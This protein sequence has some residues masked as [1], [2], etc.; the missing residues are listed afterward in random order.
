MALTVSES[1]A[2]LRLDKLLH[3]HFGAP[4]RT[5]FESLIEKGFVLVN[6]KP[7]KKKDKPKI[8]D[9]IEV[10]F[11]LTEEIALEPEAIPLDILYE[12]DHLLAINK[13][14]GMVVHPGAGHFA[15][16]FVH[17]LLYHCKNL[18][19]GNTLRPGIVHRLDKDTSGILLAAKTY[20]AHQKL[21]EL[22]SGRKIEKFYLAVSVGNPGDVT[23]NAPIRRHKTKRQEMTVDEEGKEAISKVRVLKTKGDLSLIEVEI[24][25]GRTHQ[26]RVHL[27]HHKTPI[28]G[29][30][31]YGSPSANKK[32][33]VSKQLLHAHRMKFLH[34]ITL[35]PLDLAAPLPPDFQLLTP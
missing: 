11:Q 1:E 33:G 9:E 29:D 25:T 2:G 19:F 18:P 32:Y 17:A 23:I 22:F 21:I 27:K 30:P 14:A 35:T 26:I 5:Y 16:T 20:E 31:V 12:D 7:L 3:S 6:G 10:C 24:L 34:P 13:P 28:L 15:H 4:S 8:G